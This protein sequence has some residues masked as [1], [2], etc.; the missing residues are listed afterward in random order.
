MT[1]LRLHEYYAWQLG[2]VIPDIYRYYKK[3]EGRAIPT[4]EK[5]D[6]TV[7]TVENSFPFRCIRMSKK[8]TTSA[9]IDLSNVKGGPW[10]VAI[11]KCTNSMVQKKKRSMDCQH[12]QLNGKPS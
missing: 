12:P 7:F 1:N 10:Q 8:N 9:L 6:Y 2:P 11:Q 4:P 3:Y 5:M